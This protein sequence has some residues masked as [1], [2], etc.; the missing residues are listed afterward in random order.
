M[1]DTWQKELLSLEKKNSCY[2][3]KQCTTGKVLNNAPAVDENG[4]IQSKMIEFEHLLETS[5][6]RNL[7]SN[8]LTH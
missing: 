7:R 2:S 4:S 5:G 8:N 3:E 6:E 1:S